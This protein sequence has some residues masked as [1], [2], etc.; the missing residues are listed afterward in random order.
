MDDDL[1]TAK[2]GKGGERIMFGGAVSE[3]FKLER[4]SFIVTA[5]LTLD[6]AEMAK[7]ATPAEELIFILLD[8]KN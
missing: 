3:L 6:S 4:V 8:P 2:R 1:L 5:W 7:A